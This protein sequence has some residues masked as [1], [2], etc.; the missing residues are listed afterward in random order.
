[1]FSIIPLESVQDLDYAMQDKAKVG[2]KVQHTGVFENYELTFSVV[3]CPLVRS[4]TDSYW[5]LRRILL[6]THHFFGLPPN[7]LLESFAGEQI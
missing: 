4:C 2:E 5:F 6:V 3:K 1:M 7:E